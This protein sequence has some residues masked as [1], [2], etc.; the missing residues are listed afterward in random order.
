MHKIP[1]PLPSLTGHDF[2]QN[3][4]ALIKDSGQMEFVNNIEEDPDLMR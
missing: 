2:L 3:I 1:K 4:F